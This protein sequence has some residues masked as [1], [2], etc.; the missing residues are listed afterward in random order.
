M[1]GFPY[2]NRVFER[3]HFENADYF[4]ADFSGSVFRCCSFRNVLFKEANFQN[5]VFE[6][7]TDCNDIVFVDANLTGCS[8]SI[9]VFRNI[10]FHGASFTDAVLTN[11]DFAGSNMTSVKFRGARM[12]GVNISMCSLNMSSFANADMTRIDYLPTRPIPYMRGLHLFRKTKIIENTIFITGNS[13]LE[14]TDYCIYER[15]KDKFFVSVNNVH[16]LL[17]PFAVLFLI[18]FGAFTDFGQSFTRWSLC[19]LAII[20]TFAISPVIRCGES[21]S[22]AFLVSL[23][24]FFGFGD[25]TGGYTYFYVAESILGYFMLGALISLLTSKLSIN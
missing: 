9:C 4:Q 6:N 10:N 11:V 1:I 22:D 16:P 17:R 21:L 25:I 13:H 24:A 15:R 18:L 20:S 14:F 19:T 8:M 3:E 12:N 5:C 7:C 2:T 23:L